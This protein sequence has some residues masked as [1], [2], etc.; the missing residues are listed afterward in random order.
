MHGHDGLWYPGHLEAYR[1]V[2]GVWEGYVK[3]LDGAQRDAAGVVRGGADQGRCCVSMLGVCP[4]PRDA[5]WRS[6][7]FASAPLR[8]TQK[9]GLRTVPP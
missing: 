6:R 4:N 3:L 2:E 7:L 8:H 5:P 1:K 9:S